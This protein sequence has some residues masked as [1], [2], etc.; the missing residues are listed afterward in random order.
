VTH[1]AAHRGLYP[2]SCCFFTCLISRRLHQ[3]RDAGFQGATF[4]LAVCNGNGRLALRRVGAEL[5]IQEYMRNRKRRSKVFRHDYAF[6]VAAPLPAR[7]RVMAF[8]TMR[9]LGRAIVF[10]KQAA[11]RAARRRLDVGLVGRV[12]P[13]A[14]LEFERPGRQARA[15]VEIADRTVGPAEAHAC[16]RREIDGVSSSCC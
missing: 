14:N 7:A 5:R 9:N 12:L 1:V 16:R 6:G 3:V 11:D 8:G 13:L 4:I 2:C 15:V 10:A